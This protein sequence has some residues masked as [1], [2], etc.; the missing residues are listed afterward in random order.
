MVQPCLPRHRVAQHGGKPPAIEDIVAEDQRAAVFAD[1]IAA[2]HEGL[3][4]ALGPRLGRVGE[5]HA[6]A[7]AVAEQA[8]ET[9]AVL[10]RGD[11]EHLPD[12]GEHQHRERVVDQ[13]L[14]VDGEQLLAGRNGGGVEAR[15]RAAGKNDSLHDRASTREAA[16][17][18]L[19]VKPAHEWGSMHAHAKYSTLGSKRG[20][21]RSRSERMSA[22][23]LCPQSM[24]SSGSSKRIPASWP[25][26]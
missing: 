8:G 22:S 25:G 11:D 9:L 7:R 2:D 18:R 20:S 26:E 15:P 17:A 5:G 4:D 10:R 1:E 23:A 14:V 3:G 21:A 19:W 16:C 13:R 12:A 6:D 24:A